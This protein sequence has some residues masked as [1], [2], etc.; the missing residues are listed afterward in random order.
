[1]SQPSPERDRVLKYHVLRAILRRHGIIE[2]TGKGSH[3]KFF[4]SVSGR[5]VMEPVKCHNEG[6][7]LSRK[8]VQHIR[9]KFQI[10][11]REFYR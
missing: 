11:F 2:L 7:E 10:P 1:M 3:R 6:Q 5:P 9:E 8:V 4:G